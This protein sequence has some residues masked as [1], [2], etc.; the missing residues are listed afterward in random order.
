MAGKTPPRLFDQRL[1]ASLERAA[2]GL[3]A[4]A[5]SVD[6]H[7]REITLTMPRILS[8]LAAL[9]SAVAFACCLIPAAHA[10]SRGTASVSQHDSNITPADTRSITAPRLP[11]SG[12]PSAG[13]PAAFL[14]AARRAVAAG[15]SG[16]AQEALERA[17]TRL[18][19]RPAAPGSGLQPD[20]RR[21]VLAIAAAR[22]ALAAQDRLGTVAAIDDALSPVGATQAAAAQVPTSAAS[23]L[24]PAPRVQPVTPYAVPDAPVITQALLPGHWALHGA[25]YV[26]VPPDTRL[27]PVQPITPVPGSS[28]WQDGAYVWVPPHDEY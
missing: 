8:R 2:L 18:L 27:R 25:T 24:V 3:Q 6:C 9:P 17:E 22:R 16:E 19:D 23:P 13:P 12:T 11:E 5:A 21:A 26:W 20:N 28:V 14:A 10:Q 1:A 4:E 15:R 7:S